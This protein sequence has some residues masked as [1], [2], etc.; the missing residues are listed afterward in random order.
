MRKQAV[1]ALIVGA[2]TGA[3]GAI[4]GANRAL[5]VQPGTLTSRL[6]GKERRWRWRGYDCFAAEAG[7]GPLLLL[8]HGIYAGSSSYEFRRLFPLLARTY[9]VV[10]ID[11]LGCGLSEKPDIPYSADL[12][13]EQILAACDEFGPEVGAIIGSSLGGAYAIRAAAKLGDRLGALVAISPTGL[14]GTL[15]QPPT[16]V[17]K[18]VTRVFRAPLI[19]EALFNLLASR[20]SL[21]WFLRNQA[22]SDPQLATRDV[23]D[24]YWLATHQLGA[25]YVPAHF[26]GGALNC[27]IADDLAQVEAP[28]LIA[29]GEDSANSPSPIET[30]PDYV[31]QAQQGELATFLRSKLLPHEEEPA[32][33]AERLDRFFTSSLA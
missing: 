31:T 12:F 5:R 4:A 24:H 2:G 21:G 7:T 10:A 11:L 30:A 6:G 16:G 25:R 13:V 14:D 3:A 20:P 28:V 29:W 15:D 32:E 19:G 17:G 8:V 27:D 18:A 33:L 23:I 1:A 22:Y 9:R 26:V